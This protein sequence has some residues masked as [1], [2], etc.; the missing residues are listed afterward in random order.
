MIFFL[1]LLIALAGQPALAADVL[2]PTYTPASLPPGTVEVY[3]TIQSVI[4]A[5]LIVST[6]AGPLIV[7][8]TQALAQHYTIPLEDGE[9]V[10]I[11]GTLR[12]GVLYANSIG[13]AKPDLVR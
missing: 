7:D 2:V 12:S 8:A 3:G 13:R 1:I 5:N 11:V 6:K 9:P 10:R 4:G